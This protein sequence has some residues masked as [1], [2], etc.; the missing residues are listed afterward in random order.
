M[1][2]MTI[3]EELIHVKLDKRD[4]NRLFLFAVLTGNFVNS[5]RDIFQH[6]VQID[7]ILNKGLSNE[8]A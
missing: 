8:K 3:P 5:L 2:I 7:F 1:I 6:E 4:W